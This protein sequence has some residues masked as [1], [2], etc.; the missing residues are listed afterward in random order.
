MCLMPFIPQY[1]MVNEEWHALDK[2]IMDT[3]TH[4]AVKRCSKVIK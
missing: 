1:R 3:S 4:Q 2:V